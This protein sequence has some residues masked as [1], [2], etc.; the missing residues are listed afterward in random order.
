MRNEW[1]ELDDW[2]RQVWRSVTH[3]VTLSVLRVKRTPD[4]A[5][6]DDNVYHWALRRLV[7]LS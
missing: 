7:K 4:G 2:T 1:A 6:L 3:V 5:Q